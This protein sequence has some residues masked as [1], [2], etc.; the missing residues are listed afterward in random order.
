MSALTKKHPTDDVAKISWHGGRY[1]VPINVMERYKVK[2]DDQYISV[3][4][5][6]SDLTQ[7]SGEPGVLL[8][9]LRYREG[10]SQIEFAKKLNIAQ[11]NLSAI[12]NGRRP[13]G[14]ELAKRISE[15][16]GVDYRIFL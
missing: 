2:S 14:K 4:D 7:K 16:F 5:L 1:V 6:F 13:I 12:E 10:L 9:G 15:L 8:K 3:D 11:T